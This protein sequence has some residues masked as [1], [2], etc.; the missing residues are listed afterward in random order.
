[1]D[2]AAAKFGN[3]G[4]GLASVRRHLELNSSM[5]I[6]VRKSQWTGAIEL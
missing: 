6:S 5:H 2:A 1:M 4:G 3:H